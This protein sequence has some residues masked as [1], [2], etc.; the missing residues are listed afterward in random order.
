MNNGR[1]ATGAVSP[2]TFRSVL[3][4]LIKR[5][6]AGKSQVVL[7][8]PPPIG[9]DH[10]ERLIEPFRTV[11]RDTASDL[12]LLFIDTEEVLRKVAPIWTED[13]VHLS[14]AANIAIASSLFRRITCK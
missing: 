11:V 4:L 5:R 6:V 7:L 10:Q 13:K 12:G 1:A 9:N 14:S 3:N 8:S 2:E